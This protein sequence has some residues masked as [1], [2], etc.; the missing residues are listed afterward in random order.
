MLSC[1]T[2]L[3]GV[4]AIAFNGRQQA[5][6][7]RNLEEPTPIREGVMTP[8]EIEHGRIYK[9]EYEWRRGPKLAHFRPGEDIEIVVAPPSIPG[10]P[11]SQPINTP[12][13]LRD[14]YCAADAVVIGTISN[15]A[16][17]LTED[18]TFVFTTY[19][20]SVT[21][22]LKSPDPGQILPGAGK[23]VTRPGGS[24]LLNGRIIRAVDQSFEPLRLGEQYLLF[25]GGVQRTGAFKPFRRGT[26]FKIS[27]E[28]F[29]PLG[30]SSTTPELQKGGDVQ[31]LLNL[32]Y[33]AAT[34]CAK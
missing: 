2:I 12:T 19:S 22:V 17:Q 21:Q 10:L 4:V 1:S 5:T 9:K 13:L 25:L 7:N 32:I 23:E 24:V 34:S 28:K 20:L 31:D 26:D 14:F 27:G 16:S 29:A 3:L 15:K 11:G 18:G 8:K 33:A 6:K 30:G